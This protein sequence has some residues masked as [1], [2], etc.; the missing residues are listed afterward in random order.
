MSNVSPVSV[1]IPG[2]NRPQLT[3][4]AIRSVLA[5]TLRDFEVIVV[6]DGSDANQIY[7][8]DDRR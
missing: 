1:V 6:N 2:Y 4:R 7:H 3:M 8:P 5:Q